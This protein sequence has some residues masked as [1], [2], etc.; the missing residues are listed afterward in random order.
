VI[1]PEVP[2]TK[3]FRRI[4]RRMALPTRSRL[5]D[6][7]IKSE[8]GADPSEAALVAAMAR[9][10]LRGRYWLPIFQTF[11]LVLILAQIV[12]TSNSGMR[13][14]GAVVAAVNVVALA[15]VL[16]RNP[17]TRALLL[18]AERQNRELASQAEES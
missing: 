9:R 10:H 15:V 16:I 1:V 5:T 17:R 7:A 11:L 13:V 14:L 18:S 6:L 3:E 12:L 4:Y 8:K 2:T